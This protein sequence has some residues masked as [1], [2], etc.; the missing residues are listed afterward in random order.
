MVASEDRMQMRKQREDQHF[1]EADLE[2]AN[3]TK[4]LF[5]TPPVEW[6]QCIKEGQVIPLH[7]KGPRNNLN[8]YRGVCLL[9]MA[10]RILA[11]V[12]ATRLRDW[13][14]TLN[15]LGEIQQGFRE[16]RSTADAAQLFI[17]IHEEMQ[18]TMEDREKRP[19]DP[20]ATLLDITEA[21]PRVNRPCLWSLLSK[22]GVG[23]RMLRTLEGIH[24]QTEYRISGK[25]EDGE[26]WT[27]K[28]V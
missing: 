14:E 19:E 2:V 9:A 20:V 4:E 22:L 10:S 7:K 5:V 28:G 15:L 18:G 27:P 6:T 12:L 13:A 26:P 1:S 24:E 3:L 25:E 8:N 17:R 23:N 11:R 21:Y 16:G